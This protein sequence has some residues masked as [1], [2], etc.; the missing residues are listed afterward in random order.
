MDSSSFPCRLGS[1]A[2]HPI[3]CLGRLGLIVASALLVGYGSTPTRADDYTQPAGY[4]V[5]EPSD[6]ID[7]TAATMDSNTDAGAA[8]DETENGPVR[9][10][11][12]SYISGNVSWRPDE[13][14][15]WPDAQVN[16]PLRQGAQIWVTGSGRAEV[17][18]DDGSYLRRGDAAVA[19]LQSL[20]SE[21]NGEF[22]EVR[23]NDGLAS[24]R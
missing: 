13:N 7:T 12:F 11:R 14:S 18:F 10:A 19:T 2:L 4:H 22:T 8:G 24:L 1:R 9:M 17:Q 6:D 5:G 21:Q 20:Y 23:L 15:E 3:R 16:I